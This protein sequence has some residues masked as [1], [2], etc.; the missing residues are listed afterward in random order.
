MMFAY[1]SRRDIP[2]CPKLDMLV[3][4]NKEEI[5][6]RLNS[7][8]VPWVGVPAKMISVAQK[9]NTIKLWRRDQNCSFR[10]T[11]YRNRGRTPKKCVLLKFFCMLITNCGRLLFGGR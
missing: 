4:R 7:E 11:D 9:L 1:S 3:T 5:L 2:V 10:R 6:G 8:K